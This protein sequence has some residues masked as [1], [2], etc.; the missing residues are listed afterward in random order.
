M[1]LKEEI[2]R[3]LSMYLVTAIIAILMINDPQNILLVAFS[4]FIT[5]MLSIV[6]IPL[7]KLYHEGKAPP[8]AYVPVTIIGISIP[9]LIHKSSSDPLY[10]ALSIPLCLFVI[11]QNFALTKYGK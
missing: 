2:S 3:K 7:A 6:T 1:T 8:I 5:I 9:M 10:A 11:Y 4:M